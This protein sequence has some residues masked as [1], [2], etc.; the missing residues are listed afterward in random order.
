MRKA[1]LSPETVGEFRDRALQAVDQA[2][3][4]FFKP[5]CQQVGASFQ[6]EMSKLKVGGFGGHVGATASLLP[7]GKPLQDGYRKVSAGYSRACEMHDI[8]NEQGQVSALI[9][10]MSEVLPLYGSVAM[11][12][13][14]LSVSLKDRQ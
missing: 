8:G 14:P 3:D 12:P 4:I 13:G 2:I 7:D 10:Q 5:D 1:P 11:V 9:Q 6:A